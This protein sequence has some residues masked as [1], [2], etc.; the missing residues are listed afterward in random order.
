MIGGEAGRDLRTP[1]NG[2]VAGGTV[3]WVGLDAQA[4]HGGQVGFD[5]SLVE[6]EGAGELLDVDDGAGQ[7]S[8]A[9]S[10]VSR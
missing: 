10:E 1:G 7:R 4:F 3:G 8:P 6:V 5:V 9:A 2:P